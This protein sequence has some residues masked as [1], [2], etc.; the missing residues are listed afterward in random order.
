M[1]FD[2]KV[3][4]PEHGDYFTGRIAA[5]DR[6]KAKALILENLQGKFVAYSAANEQAAAEGKPPLYVVT[7]PADVKVS[8]KEVAVDG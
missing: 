2:F 7:D 8:L 1:V 3:N 5:V 4:H 6:L